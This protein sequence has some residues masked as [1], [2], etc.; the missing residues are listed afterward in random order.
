MIKFLQ[1]NILN[2]AT[3]LYAIFAISIFQHFAIFIF[4]KKT[5]KLNSL[6][7]FDYPKLI[8]TKT[9]KRYLLQFTC[10]FIFRHKENYYY[11]HYRIVTFS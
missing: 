4:K 7:K 6:N 10:E 9:Y 5:W 8:I 11:Y 2:R 1:V 3:N